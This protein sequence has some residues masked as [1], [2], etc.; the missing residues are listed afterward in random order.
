MDSTP[1]GN[2]PEASGFVGRIDIRRTRSG[3]R[4]WPE[5]VKGRIVRESLQPGAR[6]CDVA[7]RYGIQ[8]QQLTEWRRL[9]RKGRLALVV[10]EPADF[11]AIE[12]NEP[13]TRIQTVSKV[14]IA[15]GKIVVRL[16]GDTAS[17]RI[18]EIV[19]AL[20]RGA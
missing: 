19:T 7:R 20:E 8:A 5:D 12:L 17:T 10:D 18:A 16:D 4:L 14:E 15:V 2:P 11:V 3:N 13:S 6:V 9:A 1:G